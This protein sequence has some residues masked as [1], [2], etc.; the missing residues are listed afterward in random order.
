MSPAALGEFAKVSRTDWQG[1]V[2]L[3]EL[4]VRI[5][6][7]AVLLVGC[8]DSEKSATGRVKQVFT[9][10]SFR[11][12]Q[13][14][15][16]IEVPDKRGRLANYGLRHF[17]QALLVRKLLRERVPAEQ[18]ATM[19]DGRD[20]G[21][22]ERMLLGGVEITARA[23]GGGGEVTPSESATSLAEMWNRVRV[24]PGLELHISTALPQYKPE[25]LRRVMEKLKKVLR[26]QGN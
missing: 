4:L 14:L 2:P 1:G 6:R 10:R 3:V 23:V 17:L 25:E 12:Y 24:A 8:D 22:L 26:R 7:V 13:T 9:E 20:N 21:E 15:G 19:L 16:C 5:N 18:I 11:H